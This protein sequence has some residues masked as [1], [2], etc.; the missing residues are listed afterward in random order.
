M[1]LV[2]DKEDLTFG[3][4]DGFAPRNCYLPYRE[5]STP[6]PTI[7]ISLFEEGARFS[8]SDSG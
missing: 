4:I 3:W 8:P 6:T 1:C 5:C 7:W 2:H